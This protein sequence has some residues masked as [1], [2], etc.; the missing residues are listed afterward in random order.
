MRRRRQVAARALAALRRHAMTL[1]IGRAAADAMRSRRY[2][3]Y[4][5]RAFVAWMNAVKATAAKLSRHAVSRRRAT[6]AT[7]LAKWVRY[8]NGMATAGLEAMRRVTRVA[9][10]ELMTLMF[11]VWS[12]HSL[13]AVRPGRYCTP[14]HRHAL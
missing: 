2:L 4:R 8:I 11:Q 10:R 12:R 1:G 14:R 9:K 7:A 13:C 5:P 6:K 3:G